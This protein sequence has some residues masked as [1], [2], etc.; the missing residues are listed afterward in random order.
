MISLIAVPFEFTGLKYYSF[1]QDVK[2]GSKVICETSFGTYL[3]EVTR[4][5]IP[6]EEEENKED[7]IQL[8]P[9]VLRIASEEDIVSYEEDKD[10]R[11]EVIKYTQEL[12]NDLNLDMTVLNCFVNLTGEKLLIT[13][14]AENR[15]DFR[16]LV[17]ELM[18]KYKIKIELRQLGPRDYASIIGGIGPCG[19]PLCCAT[20]LNTF[21]G[22]TINMAKNQLL[23]ININ[24]LSGQCGKLM[25]CLKYEDEAYLALRP[26]YPKIGDKLPYKGSVYEVTSINLLSDYITCYNGTNYEY[27]T[28]QEYD[29]AM[30][31][32]EKK[33]EINKFKDINSGVDLSGKGIADT[34]NRIAQINKSEKRREIEK[35]NQNLKA[36]NNNFKKNKSN[37]NQPNSN[38]KF[39]KNNNRPNQNNSYQNN[40][41]NNKFKGNRHFDSRNNVKKESGFIPVSSITDRSIL[42]IDKKDEDDNK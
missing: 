42:D 7:F 10:Y 17:K 27:F 15:V 28:R 19:L 9:P 5:R 41:G 12:A 2:I 18:S 24:K 37:N 8:F 13:F 34:N 23:T 3:G 22:I 38:N 31:G 20:F 35:D 6:S 4:I 36:N 30:L 29:R 33:V 39:N 32:M 26:S 21:D 25:C 14:S 11:K 1:N 40:K 16:E